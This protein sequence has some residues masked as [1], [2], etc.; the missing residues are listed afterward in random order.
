MGNRIKG[1]TMQTIHLQFE[2]SKRPRDSE[3]NILPLDFLEKERLEAYIYGRLPTSNEPVEKWLFIDDIIR[4]VRPR[5]PSE[6]AYNYY[7]END[8]RNALRRLE[9]RGVIVSNRYARGWF[10]KKRYAYALPF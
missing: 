7:F 1:E 9:R 8:Y 3:G 10:V 5:L 4:E 6:K 2:L